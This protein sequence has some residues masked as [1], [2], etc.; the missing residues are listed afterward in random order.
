[1]A[2]GWQHPTGTL[3]RSSIGACWWFWAGADE[4]EIREVRYDPLQYLGPDGDWHPCE[5]LD[6]VPAAWVLDARGATNI[7]VE[8]LEVGRHISNPNRDACLACGQFGCD[9][10]GPCAGWVR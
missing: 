6:L 2:K 7:G 8:A 4:C 1:M 5:P 10:Y 9:P 3:S